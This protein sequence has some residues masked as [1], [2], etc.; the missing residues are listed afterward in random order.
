MQDMGGVVVP[1]RRA[2]DEVRERLAGAIRSGQLKVDA[3][4][5][6]ENELARLFGVSRPVIREALVGLQALGLAVPR[7]GRGTF[8]ASAQ[9]SPD[10]LLGGYSPEHLAEVRRLL[11][12]P[13]ARAAAMRRS[14]QDVARL[15]AV[16]DA[17]AQQDD[18][19]QRNKLDA[20]F[21]IAIAAASGNPLLAKLVGDLRAVLENVSHVAC[22]LDYRRD[23]AQAEH[24]EIYE[25]IRR[26]DAN[27]AEAAMAA[28]LTA[29]DK[30]MTVMQRRLVRHEGAPEALQPVAAPDTTA[31]GSQRAISRGTS[32]RKGRKTKDAR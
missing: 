13:S 17:L 29:I 5:P 27:G 22:Y 9:V 31:T 10:L 28:H 21:H 25:A 20:E 4:L 16:I 18:P 15:T 30:S 7:N 26:R 19:G 14:S 11:E 12:L 2:A 6:S 8:I 1:R 24:N 23:M 32:P 3:Q